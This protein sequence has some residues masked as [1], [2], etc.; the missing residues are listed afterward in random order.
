MTGRHPERDAGDLDLP[1]GP[2]QSLRH[3]GL[4]HQERVRDLLGGQA[5]ERSQGQ[6]HLR[7]HGQRRMA[8]GEQ[9]LQPFVGKHGIV[10]LIHLGLPSLLR[11]EQAGLPGQRLLA[12]DAVDRP[13]ARRRDQPRSRVGWGPLA[14]PAGG[15]DRESLLG[16]FLGEVEVAEETDQRGE[17]TPPVLPEDSLQNLHR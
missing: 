14:R 12:A 11:G 10:Q 8:A 17:D 13:V 16:G 4:G 5:A 1:L 3:R 9:Q 7:R 15:G 6:R 2:D